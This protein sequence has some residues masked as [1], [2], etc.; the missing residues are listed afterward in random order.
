[1]SESMKHEVQISQS[2]LAE[3]VKGTRDRGGNLTV[4]FQSAVGVGA[5][6]L[7]SIC[8]GE[9]AGEL[10]RNVADS[11]SLL[12]RE[13]LKAINPDD[14]T[15]EDHRL[16]VAG[17][18]DGAPPSFNRDALYV[19]AVIHGALSA[20]ARRGADGILAVLED[21]SAQIRDG[22]AARTFR[23]GKLSDLD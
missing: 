17:V 7:A 6:G 15:E 16:Y 9:R 18:L 10:V 2:A 4:L 8:G 20:A 21:L 3:L 23:S 19:A 11:Q 5:Y 12:A 14:P 1:M 22:T 13:G